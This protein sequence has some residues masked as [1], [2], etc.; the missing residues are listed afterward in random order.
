MVFRR[1]RHE[2]ALILSQAFNLFFH[3][4]EDWR[5]MLGFGCRLPEHARK[6]PPPAS[7]RVQEALSQAQMAP[8]HR[9]QQERELR[10]SVSGRGGAAEEGFR[11]DGRGRD[12]GRQAAIAR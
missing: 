5:R 9:R 12:R 1:P 10:L 8:K 11:A 3:A 4:E 7:R 2:H 6:K